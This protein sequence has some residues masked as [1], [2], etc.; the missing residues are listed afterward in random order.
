MPVLLKDPEFDELDD[1]N[2]IERLHE[3]QTI[4]HN[5]SISILIEELDMEDGIRG[6]HPKI[7]QIRN[8]NIK[9]SEIEICK[10]NHNLRQQRIIDRKV[11]GEINKPPLRAA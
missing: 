11:I 10:L 3:H 1:C 8:L 2:G 9:N 5:R 4:K 7:N 6:N